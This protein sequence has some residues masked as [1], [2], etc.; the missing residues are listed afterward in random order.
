MDALSIGLSDRNRIHGKRFGRLTVLRQTHVKDEKQNC[1]WECVCEC[2]KYTLV[3]KYRLMSGQTESCGCLRLQSLE[4]A[5]QSFPKSKDLTGSTIGLLTVVSKFSKDRKGWKY[6]C[7]CQCGNE[8]ISYGYALLRKTSSFPA[9]CGCKGI[10]IIGQ[11]IGFLTVIEKVGKYDSRNSK[12]RCKC[13]CGK[14][15]VIGR[16]NLLAERKSPI[17]CGCKSLLGKSKEDKELFTR[18]SI[19]RIISTH[20]LDPRLVIE[21]IQR[22][23][24]E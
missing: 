18:Q 15:R 16:Q 12:Y 8:R 23:E 14:E 3:P 22:M 20:E 4:K 10:G 11:K 5:A 21:E 2:G 7:R 1:L 19:C 13:E 9:S 6:F 24:K 17:S